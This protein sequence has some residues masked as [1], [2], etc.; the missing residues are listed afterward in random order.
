MADPQTTAGVPAGWEVVSEKTAAPP[1][2]AQAGDYKGLFELSMSDDPNVR[3][4]ALEIAKTQTPEQ[5]K[6]FGDYQKKVWAEKHPGT[7]TGRQDNTLLGMPPEFAALSAAAIARA[8]ALPATNLMGRARAVVGTLGAQASPVIKYEVTKT[9]LQALGVGPGTATMIAM[10]VSGY[11]KGGMKGGAEPSA[12]SAP[13]KLPAGVDPHMPNV[14]G[15]AP[16]FGESAAG[17]R[18]ATVDPHMPNVPT[19]EPPAYGPPANVPNRPFGSGV[20]TP[21]AP[22]VDPHMPNVGA[23]APAYAPSSA[24]VPAPPPQVERYMPNVSAAPT[25]AQETAMAQAASQI[26][27]TPD[28]IKKASELLFPGGGEKAAAELAKRLGGPSEIDLV[29]ILVKRGHSAAAAVKAVA[30]TD[31]KKFGPLMTDYLKSRQATQ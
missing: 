5:Q 23:G 14:S 26:K 27:A 18:G 20:P 19:T 25:A 30:G 15:T 12:P 9:A 8:A 10:V 16:G 6:A 2:A 17:V 4:R 7:L 24:G 22:V 29:N 11:R 21:P 28:E 31:P 1:A 3:A 13:S